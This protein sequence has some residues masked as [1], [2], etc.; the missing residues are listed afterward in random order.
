ML[1]RLFGKKSAPQPTKK[2]VEVQLNARLQPIDRGELFEDPLDEALRKIGYGE[3]T[4]AGTMQAE[5]GEIRYCDLELEVAEASPEVVAF[6]I[7]T[8]EDLGAPKGS[9]LSLLEFQ[10][11]QEFGK[12]EG[13]AVYLNGT[14]L[15]PQTY[16]DCDSNFVYSEFERLLGSEGR[17]F[18]YWE[19]ATETA[20]YLYGGS[21]KEMNQ[22]LIPFLEEYPLCRKSRIIQIA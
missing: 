12:A 7:H 1:D 10:T 22:R 15:P 2:V 8:L 5:S 6:I 20:F 21:F 16:T 4:G 17:V 13:L 18:S 19:G 14:D 9:K 11:S 3:V